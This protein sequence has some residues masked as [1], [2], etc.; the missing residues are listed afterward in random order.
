MDTWRT[1][2]MQRK[3]EIALHLEAGQCGGGYG[4]AVLILCAALSACAAEVWP[5]DHI[6]RVRFTQLLKDFAPDCFQLTRV[7]IPL[8]VAYLRARRHAAESEVLGM[9]SLVDDDPYLIVTGDD[10]DQSETTIQAVC[11]TLSLKEL[12]EHSYANLLYKEIRSGYVH[13]YKPGA[14][15]ESQPMTRREDAPISYVN[16]GDSLGRHIYFHIGWMAKLACAVAHAV[17]AV[18]SDLP[19]VQPC[20]WWVSG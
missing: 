9:T 15:A 2:W 16:R 8:L 14:R 6:D 18:A 20:P 12:R 4:E 7:S 13:N 3:S 19:Q 5:G 17:D 10:V 1:E 11:P